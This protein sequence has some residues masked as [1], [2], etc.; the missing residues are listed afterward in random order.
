[1]KPGH[2]ILEKISRKQRFDYSSPAVF[3]LSDQSFPASLP[4]G[5]EGNCLHIIRLEDGSIPDLTNIFLDSLAPFGIPAGTVVL[6][7]SLSHLAWVGPAAYAEDLVRARQRITNMYQSG[8]LVLHGLPLSAS[9]S[10]DSNIVNDLTAVS[11]WL[12]LV[13]D[14]SERDISLTGDMWQARL[15]ANGS[16]PS[17]TSVLGGQPPAPPPPI[18]PP[19]SCLPP[20]NLVKTIAEPP[21]ATNHSSVWPSKPLMV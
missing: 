10:T 9:G 12:N 5:G 4:T 18:H 14:P 13:R 2:P 6:L 19:A 21:A 7:H 20:A 15:L 11:D 16:V 17:L 1:M 3:I 8:I